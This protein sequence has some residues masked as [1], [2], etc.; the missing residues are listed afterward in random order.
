MKQ[1]IGQFGHVFFLFFLAGPWKD[2]IAEA[3]DLVIFMCK[4]RS[5]EV[6]SAEVRSCQ[7]CS[8]ATANASRVEY[9]LEGAWQGTIIFQYIAFKLD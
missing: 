6:V 3:G 2:H 5:S 1:C 9:T 4:P 8:K 7:S